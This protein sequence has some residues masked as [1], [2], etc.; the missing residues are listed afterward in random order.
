MEQKN[1][2]SEQE[3]RQECW[4]VEKHMS[5]YRCIGKHDI[6]NARKRFYLFVALR[7]EDNFV[8]HSNTSFNL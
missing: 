7:R 8:T 5:I 6:L 4:I 2:T 3:I 1:S